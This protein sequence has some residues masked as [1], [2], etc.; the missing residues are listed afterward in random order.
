MDFRPYEK[1]LRAK[2]DELGRN[3]PAKDS[4]RVSDA[5]E[6]EEKIQLLSDRDV[7]VRVLDGGSKIGRQIFAALQRI[8]RKEYGTCLG[9]ENPIRENR[10]KA[11]PWAAYCL[12]CQ[13]A[14]NRG[15]IDD[16]S[17]AFDEAAA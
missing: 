16:N 17:A 12:T 10:L 15:E 9:C 11:V 1:A 13:E 7:A 5:A 6:I 3:Q 14:I 8:Q 4:I 2:L